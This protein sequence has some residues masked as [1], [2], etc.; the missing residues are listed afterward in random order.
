MFKLEQME[1]I[2]QRQKNYMNNKII[3]STNFKTKKNIQN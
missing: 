2:T 3:L 1:Q